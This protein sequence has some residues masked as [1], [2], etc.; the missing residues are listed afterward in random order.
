MQETTIDIVIWLILW[1][2][3]WIIEWEFLFNRLK[4]DYVK[5]YVLTAVYFLFATFIT[6]TLFPSVSGLFRE[7]SFY[8]LV[9]LIFFFI[10]NIVIY[11]IT[12]MLLTKPLLFLKKFPFHQ[13][14]S[15]DYRFMFSKSF[16]ILF[17]QFAIGALVVK[18]GEVGLTPGGIV[19]FFAIFF[20]LVHAPLIWLDNLEWGLYFTFS[21][22]LSAV[23]FPVLILT[24]SNGI[25]W[26]YIVHWLFYTVSSIVFWVV[27]DK[28]KNSAFVRRF[29][30]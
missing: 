4:I 27:L 21:A 19:L 3:V 17:Q 28:R 11:H 22:L 15:L 30:A 5:R 6:W 20:A 8:D 25:V 29:Y 13:W 16:E 18:L 24:F 26:S 2:L 9:I 7:L 23:A 10:I 12:P 1:A 14:L